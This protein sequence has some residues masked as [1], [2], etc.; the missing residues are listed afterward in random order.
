MAGMVGGILVFVAAGAGA[1]LWL[2]GS[3]GSMPEAQAT[4][5]VA[6]PVTPRPAAP[7]ET[8]Q[9][10]GEIQVVPGSAPAA[11]PATAVTPAPAATDP[12]DWREVLSNARALHRQKRWA[13]AVLAYREALRLNPVDFDAQ[14]Q[15][16]EAMVEL[17]KQARLEK[18]LETGTRLFDEADYGGALH[19]FYRLQLDHPEMK[20][21]ETC[22]RNAWFNWGVLLLQAGDV[23]QA[24]EKFSEVLELSPNDAVSRRSREVARRYH[25]RQRDSALESYA[26]SLTPRALDAR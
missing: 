9:G 5:S 17:E 3:G 12:A 10:G 25:G 4:V 22:I 26:G 18:D 16:D 1:W 7:A 11:A 6:R 14:D 2:G 13:E 19:I 20:Q 24:A 8:P 23:D 15:L 21:M